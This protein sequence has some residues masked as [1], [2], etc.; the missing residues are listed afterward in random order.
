[1]DRWACEE[2]L[3]NEEC[4]DLRD[5]QDLQDRGVL[6]VIWVSQDCRALLATL[7]RREPGV[8]S[9]WMGQQAN[10]DPWG[11]RERRG[12]RVMLVMKV[13]RERKG[14]QVVQGRP[15][16]R[17]RKVGGASRAKRASLASRDHEGCK[18]IGEFLECQESRDPLGRLHLIPTS[19]RCA[20]ESCKSS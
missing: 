9:A 7:E 15:A 2:G 5:H 10:R 1:M 17:A 18:E 12:R 3:E 20:G 6:R 14:R 8:Q 13:N 11:Q 19:N 4:A 16:T